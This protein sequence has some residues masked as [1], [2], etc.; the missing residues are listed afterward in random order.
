MSK[1]ANNA[2]IDAIELKRW[3]RGRFISP[4]DK[5]FLFTILF[6]SETRHRELIAFWKTGVL[7]QNIFVSCPCVIGCNISQVGP[8]IQ[9]LCAIM[10]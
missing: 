8:W 5:N 7:I 2:E 3:Q 9:G 4:D 6:F 1:T 10:Y